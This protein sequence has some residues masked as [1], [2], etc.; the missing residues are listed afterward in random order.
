MS[1]EGGSSRHAPRRRWVRIPNEIRAALKGL[2]GLFV[3]VMVDASGDEPTPNRVHYRDGP[4]RALDHRPSGGVSGRDYLEHHHGFGIARFTDA[5]GKPDIFRCVTARP[6]LHTVSILRPVV[7][8]GPAARAVLAALP[9]VEGVFA[10]NDLVADGA[11][12][13]LRAALEGTEVRRSAIARL[14]DPRPRC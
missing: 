10:T 13:V 14:R 4:K 12:A 2:F 9:D 11:L 5:V 8:A 7:R 1:G 6:D 3:G